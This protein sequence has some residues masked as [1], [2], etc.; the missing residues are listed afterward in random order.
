MLSGDLKASLRIA[1]EKLIHKT[2]SNGSDQTNLIN[3]DLLED[4]ATNPIYGSDDPTVISGIS[5][6]DPHHHHD[7]IDVS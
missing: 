4:P 6:P 5:H 2:S 3:D 1:A 7:H